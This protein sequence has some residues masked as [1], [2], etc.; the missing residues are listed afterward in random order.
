VDR[1]T[2][3]EAQSQ[4]LEHRIQTEEEEVSQPPDFLAR[5]AGRSDGRD[6]RPLTNRVTQLV[7]EFFLFSEYFEQILGIED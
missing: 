6:D 7:R 4:F 3:S 1:D 5:S 2:P